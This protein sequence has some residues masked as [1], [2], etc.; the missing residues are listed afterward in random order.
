MKCVKPLYLLLS[1]LISLALIAGVVKADDEPDYEQLEEKYSDK[2]EIR[3]WLKEH[4]P[5]ALNARIQFG[6]EY[7][8]EY[9]DA[10]LNYGERIME[11]EQ[12]RFYSQEYFET[13][14]QGDKFELKSWIV[15][16]HYNKIADSDKR[17]GLAKEL[18]QVLGKVFDLRLSEKKKEIEELESELAEL[19]NLVTFRESKRQEII[20]RRV[21][22]LTRPEDESLE[23]W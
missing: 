4:F 15:A 21:R 22:E 10:L 23:W 2:D 6:E 19:K 5:E 8:E 12:L 3:A 20:E 13:A 11:L 1:C 9:E 18:E 17:T 7:Q 16:E 14:L